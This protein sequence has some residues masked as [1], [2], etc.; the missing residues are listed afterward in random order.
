MTTSEDKNTW[1]DRLKTADNA[2]ISDILHNF[3]LAGGPSIKDLPWLG[4][5]GVAAMGLHSKLKDRKNQREEDKANDNKNVNDFSEDMSKM[6]DI[7]DQRKTDKPVRYHPSVPG[8]NP[9]VR[10]P[11]VSN[12]PESDTRSPYGVFD[13]ESGGYTGGPPPDYNITDISEHP[14][15]N[16]NSQGRSQRGRPFDRDEE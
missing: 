1:N 9:E 4:I 11:D 7:I 16:S 15:F 2:Y 6:R 13:V 3:G 8:F 14:R 10:A 5:A 12:E